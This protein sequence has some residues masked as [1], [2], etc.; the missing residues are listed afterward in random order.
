MKLRGELF[1]VLARSIWPASRDVHKE[2]YWTSAKAA[3][4]K[5]GR[6]AGRGIYGQCRVL[7]PWS[8]AVS[9]PA[10]P[11]GDSGLRNMCM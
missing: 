7:V 9:L 1:K 4:A 3:N 6:A 5:K 11:G 8:W 2:Y 10:G